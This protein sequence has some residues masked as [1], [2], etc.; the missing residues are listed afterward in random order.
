MILRTQFV[1][2]NP[3]KQLYKGGTPSSGE[4]DGDLFHLSILLMFERRGISSV[5]RHWEFDNFP[6]PDG[7]KKVME[8][9]IYLPAPKAEEVRRALQSEPLELQGGKGR[10]LEVEDNSDLTYHLNSDTEFSTDKEGIE[11]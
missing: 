7:K 9:A 2:R 11:T 5:A 1:F 4:L 8:L 6:T 10:V 3:A